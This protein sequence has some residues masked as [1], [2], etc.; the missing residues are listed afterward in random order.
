MGA[1]SHGRHSLRIGVGVEGPSDQA[2]LRTL[3]HREFQGVLFNVRA[4][5]GRTQL[6][7]QA[8]S[9]IDSFR[10]LHYPLSIILVDRDSDPC[11]TATVEAFGRETLTA[12]RAPLGQRDVVIC[13]A[14]VKLESWYLADEEAIRRLIPNVEYSAPPE[15]GSGNAETRLR[16]LWRESG[17][18][19]YPGGGKIELARAVA[20]T[21][22]PDRAKH[23]SASFAYFW[24]RVTAA[25][26][27]AS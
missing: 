7:R 8:A 25:I 15:T 27:A 24:D 16:R 2:F 21:F 1:G 22:N 26:E 18:V 20:R 12:A 13:V 10:S 3:L 19:G 14:V 4:V 23:H 5:K 6:E 17:R 11:V 9:L